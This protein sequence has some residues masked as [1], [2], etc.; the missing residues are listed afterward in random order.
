MN[1][2]V[3]NRPPVRL[4]DIPLS[5]LPERT[6]DFIIAASCSGTPIMEVMVEALNHAATDA[7][8]TPRP[9]GK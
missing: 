2:P 5:K 9:R 7:G 6:K 4:P 3:I 1:T 8:F